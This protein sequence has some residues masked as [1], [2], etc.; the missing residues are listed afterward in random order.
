MTKEFLESIIR[1]C[2]V[3]KQCEKCKWYYEEE[4]EHEEQDPHGD[5]LFYE[6]PQWWDV[7]EIMKRVKEAN[8]NE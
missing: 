8:N 4:E 6:A 1:D 5:C 7:D 2:S 3:C